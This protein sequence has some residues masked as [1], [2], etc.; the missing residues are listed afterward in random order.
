MTSR[1]SRS[2]EESQAQTRLEQLKTDTGLDLWVV[3][4]DE[5]TD[6][7]ERRGLGERRPPRLNGLGPTQYLLAVATESRQFYL[8]GYSRARSARSSSARSS[9]S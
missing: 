2:S 9:R 1:R 3:Y 5:F 7:V 4:V 6:P 8:S